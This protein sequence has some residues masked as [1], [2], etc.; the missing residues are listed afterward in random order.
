M[1]QAPFDRVPADV[2]T[3]ILMEQVAQ[4]EALP[5][6]YQCWIWD[7]IQGESLIFCNEDVADLDDNGLEQ[8]VRKSPLVQENSEITLK[9]GTHGYTFAN[10][11]FKA[12]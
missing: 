3:I 5:V 8:F 10:F 4:L 6:L 1:T 2:D 12:S 11:N 7:G 9:R